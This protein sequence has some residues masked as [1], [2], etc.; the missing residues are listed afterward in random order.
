[1][2]AESTTQRCGRSCLWCGV[3]LPLVAAVDLGQRRVRDGTAWFPRACHSCARV[4]VNE[5]ITAHR[6]FCQACIEVDDPCTTRED[7]QA[8]VNGGAR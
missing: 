4:R 5:A 8:L 6:A 7:L 2:A 1:V 3:S